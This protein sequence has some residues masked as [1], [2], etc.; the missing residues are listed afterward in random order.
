MPS[1]AHGGEDHRYHTSLNRFLNKPMMPVV[2]LFCLSD[3]FAGEA[4]A[5]GK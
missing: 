1:H 5:Q 3:V 4:F 2:K